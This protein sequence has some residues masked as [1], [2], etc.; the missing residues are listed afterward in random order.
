MGTTVCYCVNNNVTT[1]KPGNEKESEAWW[2]D[3]S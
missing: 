1:G 2:C 3:I